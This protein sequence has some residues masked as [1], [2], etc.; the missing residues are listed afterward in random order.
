MKCLM[1]IVDNFE[2]V[3]AIATLDVL[4]RG[5]NE[6]VLASLMGRKNITTKCGNKLTLDYLI[7]D[8]NP[9]DFDCLIIPGGPGSFMIMP[10]LKIVDELI[11]LFVKNKKVVASICAA[12]H[13]VGRLG[14]LSDK[15]YTVHPGFEDKIIGGKYLT[16]KGVVVDGLFITA[17][18]MYYSLE[19]GLAIHGYFYGEEAKEALRLACQGEK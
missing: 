13:L 8:V 7:E 2:D 15:S 14:Y 16:E 19:F 6:V 4:K 1:L 9:L 18:S 5:K 3:E 11:H 10:T 17:K 12:P